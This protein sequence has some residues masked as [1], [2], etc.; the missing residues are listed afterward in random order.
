MAAK[1]ADLSEE[2]VLL[3]KEMMKQQAEVLKVAM[4]TQKSQAEVLNKWIGMFTPQAQPYK[5]TTEDERAKLRE[6]MDAAQW[7]PVTAPMFPD[8]DGDLFNGI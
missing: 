7:E 3:V 8:T 2:L 5:S 4:E 1:K 6:E